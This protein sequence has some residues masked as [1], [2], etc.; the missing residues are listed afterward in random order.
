MQ[1]IPRWNDSFQKHITWLTGRL[2]NFITSYCDWSFQWTIYQSFNFVP[3]RTHIQFCS[4][5]QNWMWEELEWKQRCLCFVYALVFWVKIRNNFIDFISCIVH[6]H[7]HILLK[8]LIFTFHFSTSQCLNS[9]NFCRFLY[10]FILYILK[11]NNLISKFR[12]PS[13]SCS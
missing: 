7:E 10:H 2:I 4:N 9:L 11:V 6:C 12:V 8:N 1:V 5:N 3:F 13:M